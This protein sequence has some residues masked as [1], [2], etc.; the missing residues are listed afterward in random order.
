VL[1]AIGAGGLVVAG[2]A[3]GWV[4]P[5]LAALLGVGVDLLTLPSGAR[6]LRRIE[7]R[8]PSAG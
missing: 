8:L 6:L 5:A 7:R 1:L 2:A 3:A 4:A